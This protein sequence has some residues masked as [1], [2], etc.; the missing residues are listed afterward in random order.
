MIENLKDRKHKSMQIKI[1]IAPEEKKEDENKVMGMAPDLDEKEDGTVKDPGMSDED[2]LK[3][4]DADEALK[5]GLSESDETQFERMIDQGEQPKSMLEKAKFKMY[6][7][8]KG[9][10]SK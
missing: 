7:D 2:S 3:M 9:Y 6:C 10:K 1:E 4:K 5:G 8:K